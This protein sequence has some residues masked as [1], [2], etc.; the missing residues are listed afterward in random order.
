MKKFLKMDIALIIIC[1]KIII[2]SKLMIAII[3]RLKVIAF[4]IINN[5][6]NLKHFVKIRAMNKFVIKAKQITINY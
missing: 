6:L 4:E 1:Q 5:A 2:V 3:A